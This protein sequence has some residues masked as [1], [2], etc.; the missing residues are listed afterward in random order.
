MSKMGKMGGIGC[1]VLENRSGPSLSEGFL[2]SNGETEFE[3]VGHPSRLSFPNIGKD[4][5]INSNFRN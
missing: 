4:A 3:L 1:F 2:D 5:D